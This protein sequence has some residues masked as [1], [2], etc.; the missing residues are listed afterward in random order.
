PLVA[1]RR[2][3]SPGQPPPGGPTQPATQP[4]SLPAVGEPGPTV[5]PRTNPARHPTLVAAG[6]GRARGNGRPAGQPGR[7]PPPA[8][9]C[10]RWAGPGQ[11]PPGGPTQPGTPPWSP[12]A[13]GEDGPGGGT[14][15]A[16]VPRTTSWSRRSRVAWVTAAT[17]RSK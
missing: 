11:R 5:T 3:A 15:Q 13:V 17:A 2:R 8:R 4:S 12:P 1:A 10:R 14:R 9:C 7:P 6:G 16:G